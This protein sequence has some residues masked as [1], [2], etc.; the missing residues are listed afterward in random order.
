MELKVLHWHDWTVSQLAR[1]F[2]IG[3]TTVV[4]GAGERDVAAVR[5]AGQGDSAEQGA[6]D[7]H[8]TAAGGVPGIRGT[9]LYDE[10]RRD[11]G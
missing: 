2:G 8:G 3:R 1:E 4:Q 9:I 7:A 11:Y 10:L 6:G 5:G